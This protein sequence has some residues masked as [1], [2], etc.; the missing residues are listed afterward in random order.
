MPS[1]A[2][3]NITSTMGGPTPAF[4]PPPPSKQSIK[5][6]N[7]MKMK[8]TKAK[9]PEPAPGIEFFMFTIVSLTI[10]IAIHC[11]FKNIHTSQL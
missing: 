10:Q 3:S 2:P 6:A 8:T 5:A 4:L 11:G 9:S 7:A 1:Q